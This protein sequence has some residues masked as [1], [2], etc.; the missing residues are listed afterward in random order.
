MEIDHIKS[1]IQML[2]LLDCDGLMNHN[3]SSNN[4]LIKVLKRFL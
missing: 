3:K 2:D 1:A 4:I